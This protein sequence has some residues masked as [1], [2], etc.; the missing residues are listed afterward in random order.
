MF[1]SENIVTLDYSL[2]SALMDKLDEMTVLDALFLWFETLRENT[3]VNYCTV[4][5]I[6]MTKG[7]IDFS[8]PLTIFNHVSHEAILDRIKAIPEWTEATKQLRAACYSSFTR[9]LH[10]RTGGLMRKA[11]PSKEGHQKTFFH[12]RDKVVTPAMNRAQW[13]RFISCLEMVNKRDALIGKVILQGGKRSCEV[14]TMTHDMINFAENKITFKQSKTQGVEKHTVITYPQYLMDELKEYLGEREGLV[15]LTR[16]GRK[17][18]R[19]QI[20]LTFEKA[21]NMADIPFKVTPHV[22][23]ASAVTYLKKEG[24]SDS[25]IMKVTG[26]TS[27]ESV[28][29]YDKS[30]M[31]DNPTRLV[32][33]V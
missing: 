13:T 11:I 12:I 26:H 15:F 18:T 33:L 6:L 19:L 28:H 30:D 16:N 4:M 22:L 21:G 20:A 9:F 1:P 10:R 7:L 2:K 27:V 24:F 5:K 32:S 31:E 14:L 8:M 29:A 17:V 23:R 3:S 25:D